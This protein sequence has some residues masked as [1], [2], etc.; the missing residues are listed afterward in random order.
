M[1][2][3]KVSVMNLLGSLEQKLLSCQRNL[4]LRYSLSCIRVLR[5]R[6]LCPSLLR[7][8]RSPGFWLFLV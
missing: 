5:G 1:C 6:A 7:V 8:N 2:L 3:E 4:V